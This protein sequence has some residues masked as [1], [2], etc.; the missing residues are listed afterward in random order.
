MV[1]EYWFPDDVG[2]Y[3]VGEGFRVDVSGGKAGVGGEGGP[4]GDG[5]EAGVSYS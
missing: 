2:E 4:G 1:V 5:G 3:V